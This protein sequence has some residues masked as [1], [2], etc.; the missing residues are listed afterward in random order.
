M[1]RTAAEL[2]AT[3]TAYYNE[4]DPYNG[5]TSEETVMAIIDVYEWFKAGDIEQITG[6][7]DNLLEDIDNLDAEDH[8]EAI[9]IEEIQDMIDDIRETYGICQPMITEDDV[10]AYMARRFSDNE[11]IDIHTY[12]TMCHLADVISVKRTN[13]GAIVWKTTLYRDIRDQPVHTLS[14][15]IMN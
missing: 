14:R 1:K 5:L 8:R 2:T 13:A 7:I 10:R 4:K 12:G 11:I 6:I 9:E 15:D 3:L